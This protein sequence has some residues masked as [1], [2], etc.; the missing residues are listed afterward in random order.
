MQATVLKEMAE[1]HPF[2]PFSV[3]LNNGVEYA[4]ETP[5][6]IGA[7]RDFHMIFHFGESQAVRI[8]TESVAEV[9]E[10]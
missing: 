3:R 9:I 5:R 10:R 2:R 6:D 7:P 1:R 4:F 8:D